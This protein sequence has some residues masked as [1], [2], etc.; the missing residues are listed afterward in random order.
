LKK[1]FELGGV[2]AGPGA[3]GIDQPAG[4]TSLAKHI[5]DRNFKRPGVVT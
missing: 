1:P 3:A 5:F 4:A 2:D